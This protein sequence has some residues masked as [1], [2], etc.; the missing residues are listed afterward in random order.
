MFSDY[1]LQNSSMRKIKI[2]SVVSFLLASVLLLAQK[3]IPEQF[4]PPRL[5]SDYIG[6][7]DKGEAAALEKKLL[8]YNDSTSTQIAIVIENSLDGEDIVGYCQRLSEGWGI[9]QADKDNGILIYVAFQDRKLRIHTGYGVEGFLPD[10]MANRIIEGVIVPA[11]RKGDY[12][13][14][15]NRTADIIFDLATGKYTADDLESSDGF[16]MEA[17]IFIIIFII[18]LIIIIKNADSGG[19]Y[20][21][22]GRYERDRGGWVIIGP[23]SG[24]W[25]GGGGGGWSGGGG[26]FGGFGGGGFGG[27]G[28]SG[29]W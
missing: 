4:N 3:P 19:G 24:G 23:G 20:H 29:G 12:Y 26:G 15:F 13:G 14:G 2:L 11:F 22:G 16:P 25:N 18:V 9:G 17:L 21:R 27:G 1:G 10:I 6:L 7:L 28:A 8:A 5:V